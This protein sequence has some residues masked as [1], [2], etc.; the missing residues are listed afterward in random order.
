M[1]IETKTIADLIDA[2][3]TT[4]IRCWWAQEGIT[5]E[6]LSD[7]DRLKAALI[8]QSANKRRCDLMRAIDQRLGEGAFAAMQKTY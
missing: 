6:G 4:D 8:A 7:K 3:I 5:N 1:N 2:L